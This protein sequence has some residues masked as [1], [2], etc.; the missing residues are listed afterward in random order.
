[1]SDITR[2]YHPSLPA[3]QDVPK[4]AVKDWTDAGWKAT[5]PKHV[6]DDDAPGVGQ[7]S[8]VDVLPVPDVAEVVESESAKSE[9]KKG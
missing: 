5:K 8:P 1:M 9:P 7:W 2:V 3:W 6:D 4:A